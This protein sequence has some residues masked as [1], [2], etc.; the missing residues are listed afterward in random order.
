M[1]YWPAFWIQI[2]YII[3]IKITIQL[4][5]H[6]ISCIY[7]RLRLLLRFFYFFVLLEQF[8]FSFNE[9]LHILEGFNMFLYGFFICSRDSPLHICEKSN[10]FYSVIVFSFY[11]QKIFVISMIPSAAL[12]S[13]NP[14][15]FVFNIFYFSLYQISFID[16]DILFQFFIFKIWISRFILMIKFLFP[17][18]YSWNTVKW[19]WSLSQRFLSIWR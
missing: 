13:T 11:S 9:F 7:F 18:I 15:N 3:K 2:I 6:W 12:Y 8:L 14:L 17:F 4:W 16:F 5:I 19:T 10:S 1:L